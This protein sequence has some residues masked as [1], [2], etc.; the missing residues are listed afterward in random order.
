[1]TG[2]TTAPDRA[3]G[4][5]HT[6][7]RVIAY[8]LLGLLVVL[9][10]IG[11]SGLL[12]EALPSDSYGDYGITVSNS[13]LAQSLAFTLIA[14]PFGAFVF[15]LSRRWLTT[16]NDR[17]SVLW[18]VYLVIMHTVSLM[19]AAF[20]LL[21]V[22]SA[23]VRDQ[24]QWSELATGIVWVVVWYWHRWMWRSRSTSPRHLRDVAPVLAALFGLTITAWNATECLTIL[25]DAAI[26]GPPA[27][28]VGESTWL[29]SLGS[30]LVWF[31]GGAVIWWLHWFADRTRE[32]AAGF[33]RVVLVA[34]AGF[35]SVALALGGL[36]TALYVGIATLAADSSVL[37]ELPRA[38]ANLAV[39]AVLWAYYRTVV[40]QAPDALHEAVRIVS[41]GVSLVFAA[42]GLG[43]VVNA[44]L[45]SLT[46]TIASTGNTLLLFGGLSALVVGGV[47]W[48]LF[49]RPL[50][51]TTPADGDGAATAAQDAAVT[52][53]GRRVYL[54]VVFG[55][56][57]LI[58][59][60][61]LLIVTYEVFTFALEPFQ[62]GSL[63]DNIRAALG[64]LT[65]TVLV[66]A[67]HFSLWRADRAHVRAAEAKAAASAAEGAVTS[68]DAATDSASADPRATLAIARITL[69]SSDPTG[70]LAAS[71]AHAT[72]ATVTPLRTTET[73]EPTDV[74]ALVQ[75]LAGIA[76][77]H[78]LVVARGDAVEV[79]PL[80]E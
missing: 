9:T 66:A 16:F 4:G 74:T 59:V 72:G 62:T 49:W 31:A 46:V 47:A 30:S 23:V 33:S 51:R 73:A 37:D 21:G 26:G 52:A 10:A 55:A 35:G 38:I 54:V 22:A 53:A 76:A 64:L 61:T 70:E 34:V 18:P 24:G 5:V 75:A 25:L 79:I 42:S 36:T 63:I 65:A 13:N 32:S 44:L 8:A 80:A 2:T 69:A 1:M 7:R 3:P 67:Y 60:I 48:W 28:F 15:W 29:V 27:V 68:S 17:Y 56:S 20:S 39:G 11:V 19:V 45:A 57:T 71:L 6:L 41:S 77:T 78:V 40:R 14:G 12:S 50:G 43:V 58:A